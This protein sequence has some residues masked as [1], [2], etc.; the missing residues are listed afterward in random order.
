MDYVVD[1][2]GANRDGYFGGLVQHGTGLD[3]TCAFHYRAD[4][5]LFVVEAVVEH[6][7]G[8]KMEL[9]AD[10]LHHAL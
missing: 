1:A 4:L 8:S 10:Y 2:E 9:F 5:D 3:V 6:E 7:K